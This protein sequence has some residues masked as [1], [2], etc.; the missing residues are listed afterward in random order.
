MQDGAGQQFP[1]VIPL[2]DSSHTFLPVQFAVDPGPAMVWGEGGAVV[3]LLE[4]QE[5]DK[6]GLVGRYLDLVRVP[7]PP[8]RLQH[9]SPTPVRAV[10]QLANM[11]RQV[12]WLGK[13]VGRKL[14]KNLWGLGRVGRS[15][16]KG[17]VSAP[18][19]DHILA[20]SLHTEKC[21]PGL[22]AMLD[23]YLQDA[24]T[25]F[26]AEREERLREAGLPSPLLASPALRPAS[27][28]AVSHSTHRIQ[29][30]CL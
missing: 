15:G 11:A 2:T 12:G 27:S 1:A 28:P 23:N 17:R 16:S 24:R 20:A 19:R 26:E 25:R 21:L 3:G 6:E 7:L 13:T 10:S 18:V 8:G 5:G 30:Q 22:G 9:H 4:L 14:R 29:V